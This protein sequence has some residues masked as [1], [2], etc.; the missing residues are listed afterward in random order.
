M[1]SDACRSRV[2]LHVLHTS[3]VKIYKATICQQNK[4]C[5]LMEKG[6]ASS[7]RIDFWRKGR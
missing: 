6:L 1:R 2:R 3:M 7:E 5:A 4:G